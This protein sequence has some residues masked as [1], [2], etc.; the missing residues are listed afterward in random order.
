MSTLLYL[1]SF[2]KDR[3]VA[4]VTPTSRFTINRVCEHMEFHRDLHILEYGPGGGVF[5]RVFLEKMT[6][7]SRIVAIETNETFFLE[8]KKIN[9]PRLIVENISAEDAPDIAGNLG[10]E[11]IDYIISGIP[12]SFLNKS[13]KNGILKDAVDLLGEKG[14]F[15]AYQTSL[16]LKPYL[17][18]KFA[19]LE[20]QR[21]YLN[22]PPMC[23]Y[24]AEGIRK[25]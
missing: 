11:K 4:S 7:N 2:F 20:L 12:F 5:T 22:V 17:E 25:E 16:H 15:I 3:Q 14:R 9:D 8:L 6:S 23:I 13:A 24:I 18:E 1:K 19:R 21:E 10:W